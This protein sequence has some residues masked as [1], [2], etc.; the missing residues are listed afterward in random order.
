M[1]IPKVMGIETEF[2]ISG[3]GMADFN[4]VL[5]SS[6]LI[7]SYAGTLRKI[8]WDYEQESPLRDARGFEPVQER[9]P[10]EEDLGLANVIL[11]NG[12]RYYVDHAHPEYSTPECATP[13]SLV[14]HDKA[15]ERILE[16]SLEAVQVMLPPGQRLS[17]YKN[18]TDGKGNS[19]GTHENYLV[20]R[21]TPFSRIVRDLTPFF[22]TRQI[23]TGAGKVGAESSREGGKSVG[24][25]LSQRTDFFEAEVGLET[26]LK[27]PII[28]TR[29]EPHADPEKY[30]RL[31]CIV[32][33]ANLCE[34]ATF[35][36]VGTTA[37]IL[38]M[39]EDELLPD[40]SLEHPVQALHEI[41]WDVSCRQTVRL[42][43]GR[44][45]RALELQWEYFDQV[46][47]FVKE[48]DDSPENAEVLE[49]WE[50]VLTG[51]EEDPLSLHRELDWVAKHRLLDGYRERDGLAWRDPKMRLIDLQYHDVRRD[52]GLYQ[53]L[54][55]TG[56][57]ER[58][59]TDE[60]ISAAIMAPPE[61]TRAYFRGRCISRFP[62]SIAAAS[63]DSIIFDTGRDALQRVP[64]REPLRGSREHVEELLEASQTTAELV[65]ALQH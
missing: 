65:D 44:R 27:R 29:D 54:A 13:R 19:Y 61:E 52:R 57:V 39:I 23:F 35:L 64:T 15:G 45:V 26:T 60:E 11:P 12:A 38:K 16:R 21:K 51:I 24:Y 62:G 9:Q 14:V 41:S 50:R 40:L 43:D 59:T 49:W 33:D 22:V 17:I 48:G 20:D 53:R 8:R 1:A 32:G 25:Q 3:P 46:K 58:L 42:R 56:K 6:M 37:L 55:A 18:N 7:N 5:S 36:K 47:K 10:V 2:G 63:W 34:V 31:H 30:R 4:P 28:N